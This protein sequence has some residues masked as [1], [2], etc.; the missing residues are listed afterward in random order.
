MTDSEVIDHT[1][2]AEKS[3]CK[4]LH[5]AGLTSR[6]VTD[7][8]SLSKDGNTSDSDAATENAIGP[9]YR[10]PYNNGFGD[11]CFW[12]RGER[13]GYKISDER[14]RQA[15]LVAAGGK[16]SNSDPVAEL[17]NFKR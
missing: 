9:I 15:K 3:K 16:F 7:S 11:F 10:V 13:L 5:D 6:Q 4:E 8:V 17:N 1:R 12:N 14:S 2:E